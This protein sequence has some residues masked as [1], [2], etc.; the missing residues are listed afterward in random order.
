MK[1]SRRIS[2][3]K[4]LKI[5]GVPS[6]RANKSYRHNYILRSINFKYI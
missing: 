6:L 3:E 2:H 4:H 1:A 5:T